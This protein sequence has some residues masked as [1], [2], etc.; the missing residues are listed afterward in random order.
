[1]AE[2]LE[3]PLLLLKDME[4]LKNMRQYDL[5]MSLKR[6]LALVSFLTCITNFMLGYFLHV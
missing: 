1:M 3:K 6:D 4:A 2:A 5:F